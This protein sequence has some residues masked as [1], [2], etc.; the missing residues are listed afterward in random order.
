M[1][2]KRELNPLLIE[3][4]VPLIAKRTGLEIQERDRKTLGQAIQSRMKSLHLLAVNSYYDRLTTELPEDSQEWQN[5]ICLLTNPESY[6]FRDRGQFS[7]LERY[8]LPQLIERRQQTKTLRLWSAGCSTGEESYSLA[9][10]LDRLLPDID[11]WDLLILGT[12]INREMLQRARE[13]LYGNWSF[14]TSETALQKQYFQ[15]TDRGY[16]L[17]DRLR[18]RVRFQY[19]NLTNCADFSDSKPDFFDLIV[20]RNV[21]IYFTQSAIEKTLQTFSRSLSSDGYFLTGHAELYGQNSSLFKSKIFPESI[22]YQKNI[23]STEQD[24]RSINRQEPFFPLF[25]TPIETSRQQKHRSIAILPSDS[26]YYPATVSPSPTVAN[27]TPI[28]PE[29]LLQN[30][31]TLF[32]QKEFTAAIAN[33]E[34]ALKLKPQSFDAFYLLA[35]IYA[36]SGK[37]QQAIQCCQQAL[38][39]NVFSVKI[40]YL[41]AQISREYGSPSEEKQYYKKILYLEPHS[42]SA[43]RELA[44]LYEREGDRDRAQKM[45]RTA[46]DLENQTGKS[47][48]PP[49]SAQKPPI[50]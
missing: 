37:Y 18:Q 34:K 6:F 50:V 28:T 36:N 29:I 30:A 23:Q 46:L 19:C 7:L 12:D 3:S 14:R 40:Y 24:P 1:S 41:L 25:Q 27:Q 9:I 15:T 20:C 26:L 8:I 13:G 16:R 11:R 39:I 43:Y 2:S 5:L 4:F 42:I 17:R 47:S 48:L 35:Q 22:L 38:K 21:F 44:Y 32:L 33:A 45:Y 10:V 31:E 49:P